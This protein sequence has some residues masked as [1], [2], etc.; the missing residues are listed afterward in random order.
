[1]GGVFTAGYKAV[2]HIHSIVEECEVSKLI[3][4][5][6]LKNGKQTKVSCN[7]YLLMLLPSIPFNL[8]LFPTELFSVESSH[9][10]RSLQVMPYRHRFNTM[11]LFLSNMNGLVFYQILELLA[12]STTW[13]ETVFCLSH[14]GPA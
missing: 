2:L 6:N 12:K 9:F 3:A 11:H 7:L 4:E 5:V 8:Y 10:L 14:A 1:M 13:K